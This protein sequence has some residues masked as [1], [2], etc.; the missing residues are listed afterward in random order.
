M[1]LSSPCFAATRGRRTRVPFSILRVHRL[2]VFA[3]QTRGDVVPTTPATPR[4]PHIGLRTELANPL[5]SAINR[6]RIGQNSFCPDRPRSSSSVFE[7]HRLPS[8]TRK[9]SIN[10]CGQ[11]TQ[12]REK[13]SRWDCDRTHKEDTVARIATANTNNQ[14]NLNLRAYGQTCRPYGRDSTTG[15]DRFCDVC[16]T[17]QHGST[18]KDPF[19][20]SS[21]HLQ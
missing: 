4:R 18:Y 14:P 17:T 13:G 1:T 20:A 11:T 10:R 3:L 21:A 2:L 16:L 8:P 9:L 6:D 5:L 7:S 15:A 19:P 12:A